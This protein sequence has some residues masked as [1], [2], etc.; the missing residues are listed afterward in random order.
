V[1]FGAGLARELKLSRLRVELS[2]PCTGSGSPCERFKD[3]M[4]IESPKLQ[5]GGGGAT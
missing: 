5:R 4:E 1:T 2:L 3:L